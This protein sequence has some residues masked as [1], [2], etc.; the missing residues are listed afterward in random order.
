MADDRRLFNALAALIERTDKSADAAACAERLLSLQGSAP[1]AFELSEE[2]IMA[3]TGLNRTAAQAIDL[4]DELSRYTLVEKLGK[5][6]KLDG[7]DAQGAY[8]RALCLGRHI[9]YCYLACLDENRRLI[10]CRL[11]GKGTLD[12]AEVYV[13][14][15]AQA[16]LRANA[17][18]ACL[19][20][21]HPGGTLR[22]SEAD[23]ELTRRAAKAL[24]LIGVELL[25]HVIVTNGAYAGII[26]GGFL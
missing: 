24:G 6:P 23:I 17:K 20:H 2:D 14:N 18:Y 15:I 25:E 26:D 7:I 5:N 21:N 1:R 3:E 10:S 13:R 8:F 9:E 4:I 22:P 19:A 12:A 16:A 11:M